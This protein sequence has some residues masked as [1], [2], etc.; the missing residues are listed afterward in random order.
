MFSIKKPE[1]L[2]YLAKFFCW[3]GVL[4]FLRAVMQVDTIVIAK[5]GCYG[6]WF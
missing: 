1:N 3:Q 4:R 6:F 2:A 5:S